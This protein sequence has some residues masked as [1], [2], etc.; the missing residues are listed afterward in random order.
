MFLN[1][2]YGLANI[3]SANLFGL[4]YG[5]EEGD[6][7][8][9]TSQIPKAVRIRFFS[10]PKPSPKDLFFERTLFQNLHVTLR[11]KPNR[12]WSIA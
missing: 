9:N 4:S 5:P 7:L 2:V 6:Q 8:Q 3:L 11:S 12:D 10:R 1:V